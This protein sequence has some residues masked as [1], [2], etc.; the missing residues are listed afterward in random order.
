[1]TL[2]EFRMVVANGL[3]GISERK[4][5]RKSTENVNPFKIKVAQE[6][7]HTKAAHISVRKDRAK[8]L[9][10]VLAKQ[11]DEQHPIDIFFKNMATSVKTLSSENQIR[12]K[13]QICQIV[14]QLELDEISSQ[15]SLALRS[16]HNYHLHTSTPD[17]MI[18]FTSHASPVS[19]PDT[20][21]QKDMELSGNEDSES[22]IPQTIEL[23][24]K[25]GPS[26][27]ETSE[28]EI[29]QA[30]EK[31][32]RRKKRKNKKAANKI[33]NDKETGK[34]EQSVKENPKERRASRA[35]RDKESRE[36]SEEREP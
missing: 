10:T 31:A 6:M 18:S 30:W 27:Q 29:G 7:R 2:K 32:G 23:N 1:M 36:S 14:G 15:S 20:E 24:E 28:S 34:G 17:S 3:I 9:S 4:R 33:N 22:E 25:P 11:T 21:L 16:S 12:A 26:R 5:G 19:L 8:L 13:M 35:L